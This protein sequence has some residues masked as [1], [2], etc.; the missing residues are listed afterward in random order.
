MGR[1]LVTGSSGHLGEALMRVF[2]GHGQDAVGLD[3]K[4]SAYT[5]FAGSVADRALLH[6]ALDGAT[7]VIHAAA[8]HKPHVAT[9]SRRD[10]VETNVAG[11]LALLEAAEAAGVGAFVFT[12]TT[13]AFGAALRPGPGEPAAWIDED[14]VPI[15]RNIYGVTKLAAEGLVE[16]FAREGRLPA[17]ILRTSRFFPEDDDDREVRAIFETPNVQANELLARRA[18]IADMV[19]AHLLALAAAPRLGFGRYIVSATTPFA[20]ADLPELRWDLPQLVARLYPQQPALY[21]ARGWRLFEDI[22]RVYDNARARRDLGWTPKY[23]FA[24]VLDSLAEGEDF[25]SPLAQAVGVKGYHA[26]V[27]E[28]GPY[29]VA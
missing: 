4:P 24:H 26:E 7:G 9:H 29:P 17:V 5:T 19:E 13:S 20:P 1:I 8:L 27:F 18:D 12:S 2:A 11:T 22:D 16:L 21:A 14:V 25:R 3:A 10:F 28:D 6:E 15:P 23:D